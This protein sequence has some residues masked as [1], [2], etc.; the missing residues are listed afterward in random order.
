MKLQINILTQRLDRFPLTLLAFNEIRSSKYFNDIKVVIH[1]EQPN[2]DQWVSLDLNLPNVQFI[3]YPNA[4]YLPKVHQAFK[5]ECIY[6]CKMDDDVFISRFV[7]DYIYENLGI[8]DSHSMII[9]CFSNGVPSGDFFIEDV[10]NPDEIKQA[11]DIFIKDSIPEHMWG[12]SFHEPKNYIQNTTTWNYDEYWDVF[13][14][15]MSWTPSCMPFGVHPIRF[16]YDYHMFILDKIKN[17]IN[18]IFDKQDYYMQPYNS[19]YSCNNLFVA[20]TEFW[21]KSQDINYDGWDEGQLTIQSFYDNQTPVFIRNSN[22]IHMAYGCTP[23]QLEI[24]HKFLE[25]LCGK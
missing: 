15:K 14:N 21:I 20:K 22:G 4:E 11:H 2:F 7:W 10:L 9:P 13:R 6:S 17:N 1:G 18:K 3:Q 24:E 25:L 19:V 16:S 5:T 12:V 8:L 23:N